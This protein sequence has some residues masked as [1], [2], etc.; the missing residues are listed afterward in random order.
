MLLVFTYTHLEILPL[1][2]GLTDPHLQISF[3]TKLSPSG[4]V[5]GLILYPLRESFAIRMK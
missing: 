1:H 3:L 4:H 2:N 5:E